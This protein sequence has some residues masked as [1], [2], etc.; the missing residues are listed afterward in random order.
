M[1]QVTIDAVA[2]ADE[3]EWLKLWN[4]Y[5]RFYKTHLPEGVTRA[6]WRRILDDSHPFKCFVAR[7]PESGEILGF[8]LHQSHPSSWTQVGDMY[9]EDLFVTGEARGKG[10]GRALIEAVIDAAKKSRLDRVYWMTGEDNHTARLLYDNVTGGHDG[11][12]RYRIT[13]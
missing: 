10:I 2:P 13:F 8:A 6:T 9:L 5:L 7:D 3:G 11:H 4:A 1:V 12:V